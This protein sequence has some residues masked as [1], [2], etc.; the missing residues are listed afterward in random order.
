MKIML[1]KGYIHL[2]KK[3]NFSSG[4]ISSLI[5]GIFKPENTFV[6]IRCLYIWMYP[7]LVL[8]IKINNYVIS[9]FLL[10]EIYFSM[11]RPN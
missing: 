3:Y 9:D 2:K 4:N 7:L 11:L 10:S 6:Y 1:R 5:V 8:F